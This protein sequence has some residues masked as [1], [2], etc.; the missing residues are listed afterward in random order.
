MS[1]HDKPPRS[2][3]AEFLGLLPFGERT[4]VAQLLRRETVGGG[5][6]LLAA[7]A[8][9]LW[10]NSPWQEAYT[11][12][13]QTEIGPGG[14]DLH[15]PLSEWAGSGLLAI[16]FF[17]AGLELKRE[18]VHGT[19]RRPAEAVLPVAA[20]VIGMAVPAL[21]Y[22]AV[23]AGDAHAAKGWAIPT[24]TDIAF[25]LAVLA[26]VGRRLPSALRAFLLTLAVVD[27]LIAIVL[28]AF[29]YSDGVAAA[30]LAGSAASLAAYALLQRRGV[31][32][33]WVLAPLALLAWGFMHASG[34][35]PTVAGVALGLLTRAAHQPDGSPGPVERFAHRWQP[36]SAGVAVPLFALLSVGISVSVDSLQAAASDRAAVAV[37]VARLVGKTVGVFAG[38]YLVARLTAARL[39]PGLRWADVF[40]VAV[41]TGIGFAVPLLVSD[42]AFG[43]GSA[44]DE[45]ITAG[46]L[47][48]ALVSA[49][50]GA[51]LLRARHR[52][53]ERL[54]AE[55]NRDDDEDGVPDVYRTGPPGHTDPRP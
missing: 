23:T 9:L 54:Y 13:Q 40:S 21:I 10:A 7:T 19:L 37:V 34:V 26:V 33:W 29:F 35:H 22:L 48:A 15:L 24:A 14:L 18:L 28:I 12:L 20:A 17:V 55:E 42:V 5:L 1:T 4:Y 38:A 49:C 39:H 41:L 47:A 31:D 30:P 36:L 6:I 44:Q 53:Y 3:P 2:R 52:H 16:F 45:R 11:D 25:C 27:D 46:I 51:V 32:S 8:A 50:V 43:A